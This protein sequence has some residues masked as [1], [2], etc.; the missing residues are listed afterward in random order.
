MNIVFFVCA[1]LIVAAIAAFS[2]TLMHKWGLVEYAQ[3]HAGQLI[4]QMFHCD[5]CLS[6][7]TCVILS[8]LCALIFWHWALLFVPFIA[9]PIARKLL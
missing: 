9:T 8:I 2:V 7:W 4:S 1:C 6:W 3:V 5:F